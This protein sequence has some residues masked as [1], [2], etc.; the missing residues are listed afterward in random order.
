MSWG[1]CGP[2]RISTCVSHGTWLSWLGK[3]FGRPGQFTKARRLAA[4]FW[5]QVLARANERALR[6]G[7]HSEMQVSM[8][9]R[10]FFHGSE[11]HMVYGLS[12]SRLRRIIDCFN[13]SWLQETLLL[14]L[15]ALERAEVVGLPPDLSM[16]NPHAIVGSSLQVS[17]P[18]LHLK[19]NSPPRFHIWALI[20]IR[21]TLP[22]IFKIDLLGCIQCIPSI[23]P[24]GTTARCIVSFVIAAWLAR[25]FMGRLNA[26][27]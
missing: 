3:W 10:R 12:S 7:I 13:E 26:T 25:F 19:P 9:Y 27:S 1:G 2:Q 18:L 16:H 21:L 11:F 23:Q 17:L 6:M 15:D 5:Y 22:T 14:R 8:F 24:R 4:I 20:N